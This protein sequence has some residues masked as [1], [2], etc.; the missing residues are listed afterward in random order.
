MLLRGDDSPEAIEMLR[1]ESHYA[2]TE[3]GSLQ[4][5]EL[6]GYTLRCMQSRTG[7]ALGNVL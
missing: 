1:N 2:R 5:C 3:S 6:C 4:L 7:N